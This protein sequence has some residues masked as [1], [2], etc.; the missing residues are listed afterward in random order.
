MC[1]CVCERERVCVCLHTYIHTVCVCVCVCLCVCVCVGKTVGK[2]A[3]VM[4][5]NPKDF[6]LPK[7]AFPFRNTAFYVSPAKARNVLGS[8]HSDK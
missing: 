7:G 2:E 4:G 6:D 1:V 5:Y 8:V 3:K